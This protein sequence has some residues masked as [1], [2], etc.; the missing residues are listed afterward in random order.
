MEKELNE[1][2]ATEVVE[3]KVEEPNETTIKNKDDVVDFEDVKVERI[4]EVKVETKPE[5]I[6]D[7]HIEVTATPTAETTPTSDVI[8]EKESDISKAEPKEEV[9]PAEKQKVDKPVRAKT[10]NPES[11]GVL[12]NEAKLITKFKEIDRET[13]KEISS[14][15]EKYKKEKTIL[16]GRIVGVDY[17]N[18]NKKTKVFIQCDWKEHVSVSIADNLYFVD[19]KLFGNRYDK[20]TDEEKVEA[21]HFIASKHIGAI[22]CFTVQGFTRIGSEF[23]VFGDRTEA[24][25][26]LQDYYFRHEKFPQTEQNTLNIGD[27]V[28][29]HVLGVRAHNILVECCGVETYIDNFAIANMPVDNCKKIISQGSTIDVKIRKIHIN[30]DGTN[31]LTVVGRTCDIPKKVADTEIGSMHLAKLLFKNDKKGTL[32]FRISNGLNVLVFKKQVNVLN[33]DR[34]VRGDQ[35]VLKIKGK[36]KEEEFLIGLIE[37]KI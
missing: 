33:P 29:A 10:I 6:V 34:L 4:K 2:K 1:I 13:E 12:S 35:V 30:D 17:D 19:N 5:V 26:L 23:I 24:L 27:I 11:L 36:S 7:T 9:K 8:E 37:A 32:T 3:K 31:Y 15:L 28:K 25:D 22:I 21:R 20:M 18:P 16:W 14:T